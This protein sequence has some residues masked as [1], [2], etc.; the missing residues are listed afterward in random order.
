MNQQW[1]EKAV[2][3]QAGTLYQYNLDSGGNVL[4]VRNRSLNNFVYMGLTS[5]LSNTDYEQ[6]ANLDGW[7]VI[8]RPYP[9]KTVYLYA[10][11]NMGI[12]IFEV[13][14]PDS[15]PILQSAVQ[16]A[17]TSQAITLAASIP[18]GANIIGKVDLSD[19]SGWLT[20][21]ITAA[22]AGDQTVKNTPGTVAGLVV[23]TKQIVV[24]LKDNTVNRWCAAGP[25]DDLEPMFPAI[26][27]WPIACSNNIKLNFSTGGTAYIIYK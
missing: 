14:L 22:G 19:L 6:V 15:T 1:R 26:F 17:F 11:V 7:G 27:P 5:S 4:M 9:L 24:T 12:T 23:K 2:T 13:S 18:A 20:A 25:A 8:T 3:L 10:T 16:R 21:E